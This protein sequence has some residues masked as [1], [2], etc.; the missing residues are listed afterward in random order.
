MGE[1]IRED[2]KRIAELL[3][4]V[5]NVNGYE[6]IERMGGLTNHT[7]HVTLTDGREYTVRIP[8]EGTEDMINRA[9]EKISTE[10]ACR[11][12]IDARLLAFYPDG[13][14]VTE[15][16]HNAVTM[17]PETMQNKERIAKAAAICRII[18]DCGVDTGVPFEVFDMA[19]TYEGIINKMAVPMFADYQENK[20]TV[21]EIKDYID[22][23]LAPVK[24]PC[25]NDPLCAN[26]VEGD[27]KL[28]L[29]DWE[30]AGMN[31]GYWDLAAISIEAEYRHD[32]DEILLREYL[33]QEADKIQW[34][35]F[36]AAKI[37]VDYLW[38]LWAK[39]RV[40]YDGQP[41]E[42]WACERYARMKG[43]IE[44]FRRIR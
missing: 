5:L 31:D 26:W 28:Y 22:R 9:D 1:I 42:D 36:L 3:R 14:K 35:H 38:T 39:T 44:E 15:Y 11:L 7:Y 25:H 16:I 23:T 4:E 12:G 34:Q 32:H 27:G 43:N 13:C 8:G 18:H 24:V 41:M 33:G 40:P 17:T 37:Y 30:Y 19:A 29:I 2:L 10:L 21:M 20:K 6:K